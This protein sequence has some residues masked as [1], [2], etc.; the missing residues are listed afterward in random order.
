MTTSGME[1]N[2]W[3][4]FVLVHLIKAGVHVDGF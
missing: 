3:P 1:R 2:G 4:V